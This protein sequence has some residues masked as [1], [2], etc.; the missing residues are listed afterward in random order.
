M[1]DIDITVNIV[2]PAVQKNDVGPA[3]GPAS[4][5]PTF[6]RPASICFSEV[7]DVFVPG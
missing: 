7:N 3:A 6:R 4:T 5:Y 1:R 2:G